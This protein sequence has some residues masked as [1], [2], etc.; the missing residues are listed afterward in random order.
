MITLSTLRPRR[1]CGNFVDDIIEWGTFRGWHFQMQSF[2]W[3]NI[4]IFSNFNDVCCQCS[5]DQYRSGDDMAPAGDKPIPEPSTVK[6][7]EA[8]MRQWVNISKCMNETWT[9]LPTFCRRH[10][11]IPF[12]WKEL[13]T[14]WLNLKLAPKHALPGGWISIKMP[15]YQYKKSH[16]RDKTILW[17]S[18]LHNGI[19]YNGKTTSLYWIGAQVT[20]G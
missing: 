10:F 8:C 3:K 19:S 17:P 1:N 5:I 12:C 2:S 7:I 13:Y 14:F 20:M 9:K 11:Q 18:Y 16:C 15:S 4:W 6:F